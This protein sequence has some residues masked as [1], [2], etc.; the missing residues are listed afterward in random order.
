M[1][2]ENLCVCCSGAGQGN[3]SCTNIFQ[4]LTERPKRVTPRPE[5]RSCCSDVINTRCP[6]WPKKHNKIH[7]QQQ[8]NN[9]IAAEVVIGEPAER[10]LTPFTASNWDRWASESRASDRQQL[11][12]L[13][14]YPCHL[15]DY[16]TALECGVLDWLPF[17][18]GYE[19]LLHAKGNLAPKS[20][21]AKSY[22]DV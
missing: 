12:A 16:S 4:R 20:N 18:V 15:V 9:W 22:N 7:H 13:S 2:N 10:G 14:A 17:W 8:K 6:A 19:K 21:K 5:T 3:F 11:K 1:L